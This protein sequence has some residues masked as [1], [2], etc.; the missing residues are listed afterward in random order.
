MTSPDC[1]RM[2]KPPQ[3]LSRSDSRRK[4]LSGIPTM[5]FKNY[6]YGVLSSITQN[7]VF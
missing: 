5:H 7:T 4:I 2:T 3:K 6:S 1:E